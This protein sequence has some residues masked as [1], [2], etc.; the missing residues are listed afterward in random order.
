M[1]TERIVLRPTGRF[2]LAQRA[3]H[4]APAVT[5]LLSALEGLGAG[6]HNGPWLTVLELVVGGGLLLVL[7]RDV[8]AGAAD[9]HAALSL[10]DVIAAGAVLLEGVHRY[11]PAKGF[12]PAWVYFLIAAATLVLG[13]LHRRIAA[14]ARAEVGAEG[15]AIRWRPFRPLRVAWRDVAAIE[16]SGDTLVVRSGTAGRDVTANLRGCANLDEVVAA[17]GRGLAR[18]RAALGDAAGDAG[19]APGSGVV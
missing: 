9:R 16:R 19:A 2:L 11:N 6:R 5:L 17:L 10:F 12:Q 18:Y 3:N 7:I 8:R 15:F 1:E 14:L 13:L 4:I